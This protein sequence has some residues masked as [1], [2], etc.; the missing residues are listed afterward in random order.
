MRLRGSRLVPSLALSLLATLAVS[1]APQPAAAAPR[2]ARKAA[3]PKIDPTS[4]PFEKAQALVNKGTVFAFYDPKD[5]AKPP[6]VSARA[7]VLMDV[8]T[9]EILWEKNGTARNYP[10]STTKILTG[11]LLAEKTEP[12]DVVTCLDPKIRQIEESS[13]HIQPWEKFTSK[14]LLYGVMLRSANDGAVVVAQHVGGS[15]AGFADLMN[16]RAREAGATDTHFTNPNGLHDPRHW[17][18]ARDLAFITRAALLNE[19]FRDAVGTRRR[20]IARSKNQKDTV[21]E[22][23]A[24]KFYNTFPGAN[25]VKTGYTRAAKYCFVG[26]ATRDGRQL[27]GVILGARDNASGETMPLLSWGFRRFPTVT[28]ARRDEPAGQVPV[29]RGVTPAV[30]VLPAKDVRVVQDVTQNAG[31]VT[32]EVRPRPGLTAPIA[33]GQE[34]GSLVV[35]VEGREKNSTPLLAAES[36]D[37]APLPIVMARTAF[38]PTWWGA[39]GLAL[40]LVAFG[41]GNAVTK[42]ARRRRDSVAAARRRDDRGRPGANRR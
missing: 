11:L 4:L 23:K 13:L 40:I 25:G 37:A 32:T 16:Q 31:S 29:P 5:L 27:V 36:V 39:G 7:A 34:V 26:A 21:V 12:T 14:D 1:S 38:V 6:V 41:Y 3:A 2:A 28:V 15:V 24:K 22:S 8:D 18:T 42:G 17:T 9:G 20:V 19:R 33:A 30:T 10:A 35:K